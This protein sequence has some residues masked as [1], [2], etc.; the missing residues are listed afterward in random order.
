M[1]N[2]LKMN[3]WLLPA[4]RYSKSKKRSTQQRHQLNEGQSGLE[5][6]RI[7]AVG[8][9]HGLISKKKLAAE[10]RGETLFSSNEEKVKWIED[11]GEREKAG[12]RK[13]VEDA[14]AGIQEEQDDMTHV[15]IAG[16]TS[17]EPKKTFQV[18]LVAIRDSLSDLIS[19]DDGE[20][21]EEEDDEDTE[22]GN[23]SEDDEPGWV[24]GTITKTVQQCMERFQQK[25]TDLDEL[26]QPRWEDAADCIREWEKKYGTTD[27]WVPAIYQPQTKDDT[28]AP[29]PATFG[30]LMESVDIVPGIS[31]RPQGTTR[32]GSSHIRL[33]LVKLQSK[34]S[35]TSCEPAAEPDSSM[36]LNVI[37]I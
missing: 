32:P 27:L 35:M 3:F 28:P 2:A 29:L 25:Q 20:D 17:R 22:Q 9:L 34:S 37:P 7:Q 30:E 13:R 24:L 31:Q 21:G 6:E 11:Y 33:G 8:A 10:K 19:S 4:S 26:T 5:A 23:L 36:L 12:P 15:E 18:M 14:E 16:L 1:V